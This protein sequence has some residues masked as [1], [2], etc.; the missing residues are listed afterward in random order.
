MLPYFDFSD[1]TLLLR[2]GQEMTLKTEK[3][4]GRSPAPRKLLY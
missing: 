1:Y 3:D 2:V 4:R